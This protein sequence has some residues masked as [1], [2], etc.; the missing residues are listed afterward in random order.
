MKIVTATTIFEV[1]MNPGGAG[2]HV[3]VLEG[4]NKGA[5]RD[6]ETISGAKMGAQFVLSSGGQ[7]IIKSTTVQSVSGTL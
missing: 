6:G 3:V 7:P 5:T 1:T 4:K 2:F